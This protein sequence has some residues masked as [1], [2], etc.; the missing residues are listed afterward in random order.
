M[1]ET[2][3]PTKVEEKQQTP[4]TREESRYL[5]PPVDIYENKGSLNVVADL[6]GVGKNNVTIRVNNNVLTI[7]GKARHGV[8]G[9]EIHDE[10]QLLDFYRQF[11]LDETVNQEKIEAE[12]KN[13]VLTVHL[14]KAERTKPREIKVQVR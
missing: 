10:F 13:G 5:V 12:M 4:A 3:I 2:T 1:A 8:P 6:P 7:Q 14:P 9:E 11:Q